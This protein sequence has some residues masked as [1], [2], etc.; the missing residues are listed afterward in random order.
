MLKRES[1]KKIMKMKKIAIILLLFLMLSCEKTPSYTKGGFG[2]KTY[3]VHYFKDTRTGLCF[4][5]KGS[6][7]TYTMTCVPCSQEVENLINK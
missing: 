1:S 4:A 5:E 6:G 2:S 7:N 3:N